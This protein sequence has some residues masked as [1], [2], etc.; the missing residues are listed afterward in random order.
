MS[1]PIFPAV[2][3]DGRIQDRHL[4]DRLSELAIEGQVELA[5]EASAAAI[6]AAALI[7]G[8][9]RTPRIL[10]HTGTGDPVLSSFPDA[11]VGDLIERLSDGQRWKVE[12]S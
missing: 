2:G 5:T 6:A 7:E 12:A 10:I 9:E 8:M 4:P 3:A 1:A 11:Q